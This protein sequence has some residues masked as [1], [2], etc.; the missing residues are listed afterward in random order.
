MKHSWTRGEAWG[1][2]TAALLGGFLVFLTSALALC[3]GLPQLG[4]SLSAAIGL[5]VVLCVPAWALASG[6]AVLAPHGRGAWLRLGLTTLALVAI[7]A[8]A[9]LL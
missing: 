1:K 5:S 7:T 9:K 6:W 2:A 3:T 8:A 4:V